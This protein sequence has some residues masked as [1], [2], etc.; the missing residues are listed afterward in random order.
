MNPGV[1][2]S[3]PHWIQLPRR[4]MRSVSEGK[5]PSQWRAATRHAELAR[6]TVG[7]VNS[8]KSPGN[9]LSF[10][11]N[12]ASYFSPSFNP[13]PRSPRSKKLPSIYALNRP[14]WPPRSCAPTTS[15]SPAAGPPRTLT[16]G[17]SSDALPWESSGSGCR[18]QRKPPYTRKVPPWVGR[19]LPGKQ[20]KST[21]GRGSRT[22]RPPARC[23]CRGSP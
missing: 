16:L 12:R 21:P 1:N 5:R 19:T 20:R 6:S 11:P 4:R 23:R 3:R 9:S 8:P 15:S 2:P 13:L 18:S 17:R 14:P 10:L 7:R 22:R